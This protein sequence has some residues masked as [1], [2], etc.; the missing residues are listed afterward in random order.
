MTLIRVWDMPKST[1]DLTIL[2]VEDDDAHATLIERTLRRVGLEN[3]IVRANNGQEAVDYVFSQGKY[4]GRRPDS[5]LVVFLDL[6]LPL[7]SGYQV[8]EQIKSHL[9]TRRVPVV[10]ISTTDDPNEMERCYDLGAN[11]YVSKPMEFD[12]FNTTMRNLGHFLSV[13]TV[14]R[15]ALAQA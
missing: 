13:M 1:E 2:M 9:K 4:T 15:M 7:L 3:K 14:P 12:Q 6:N 5:P 11:A 10:I 8:L